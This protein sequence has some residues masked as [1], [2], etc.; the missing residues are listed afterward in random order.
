MPGDERSRK[1]CRMPWQRVSWKLA[2][3]R[4]CAGQECFPGDLDVV[5]RWDAVSASHA[6][7]S[8][9]EYVGCC[10]P[11]RAFHSAERRY[12]RKLPRR[13]LRKCYP[14]GEHG[15]WEEHVGRLGGGVQLLL[16]C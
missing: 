1:E 11:G 14:N 4:H 13:S 2:R 6:V 5:R 16:I 15:Q 12:G 7:A 3:V 8:R 10:M 9:G